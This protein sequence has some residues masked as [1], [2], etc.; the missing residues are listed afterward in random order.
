[1]KDAFAKLNAM[2]ANLLLL[3]LIGVH[4]GIYFAAKINFL[5]NQILSFEKGFEQTLC[6]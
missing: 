2:F 4:F 1:M 5:E 3:N 6:F